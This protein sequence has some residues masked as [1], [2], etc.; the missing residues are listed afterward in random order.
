MWVQITGKRP[1]GSDA[2]LRGTKDV[3]GQAGAVFH[4]HVLGGLDP[5][6]VTGL[7]VAAID[8][9]ARLFVSRCGVE[10]AKAC[11]DERRREIV[12][13][14]ATSPPFR[15]HEG[16]DPAER[17]DV[18]VVPRDRAVEHDRRV[19]VEQVLRIERNVDAV[20]HARR[21]AEVC[22]RPLHPPCGNSRPER[23]A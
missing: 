6:L 13:T 10:A 16:D 21:V 22:R 5:P 15:D 4:R 3:D 23:S 1:V 9:R 20:Q 14:R 17:R 11:A 18:L 8:A 19:G 2:V 12:D 7:R